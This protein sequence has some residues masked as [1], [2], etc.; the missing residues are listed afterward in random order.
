MAGT[1]FETIYPILK[2]EYEGPITDQINTNN[3]LLSELKVD[4]TGIQGDDGGRFKVVPLR[5][6]R[7][8]GAGPRAE[9]AE[10][11]APGHRRYKRA[12]V[13]LTRQ[14]A[15]A[16]LSGF[17][18]AVSKDDVGAFTDALTDTIESVREAMEQSL[19]RQVHGRANGTLARI[20]TEGVSGSGPWELTLTNQHAIVANFIEDT[21]LMQLASVGSDG[22]AV[23]K[24]DG[25]SVVVTDVNEDDN[26]ITVATHE[27]TPRPAAGD[28]L[29]VYETANQCLNGIAEIVDNENPLQDVD[30]DTT[31]QW[32]SV[33]DDPG[34]AR[35][36]S[37]VSLQKFLNK[38][39]RKSGD[40]PDLIY[41]RM[42]PV[43]D[44][45]NEV[46][47]KVRFTDRADDLT[48]GSKVHINLGG[49][50]IAIKPDHQAVP[51]QLVA[52]TKKHIKVS[53][54]GG[55]DWLTQGGSNALRLSR[56]D[57]VEFIMKR[58][59][60]TYTPKRIAH[61]V[62]KNLTDTSAD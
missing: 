25:A 5:L 28:Y 52:L 40:H 35:T 37:W 44:L 3:A 16:K 1:V 51:D 43:R 47:E 38:I 6:G 27:G 21:L 18:E 9:D 19:S 49:R 53:A 58:Y 56:R 55:Y 23:L 17:A 34:S 12:I 2:E 29:V 48:V 62:M 32:Q 22:Q 13:R 60:N 4:S 24:Y 59:M 36:L 61:G 26:T 14:Y 42:A 10:L 45:F 30:P 8:T 46:D 31:P 57:N 39:Y 54:Y 41:A 7:N 20:A 15:A 11:P 50:K 33:V